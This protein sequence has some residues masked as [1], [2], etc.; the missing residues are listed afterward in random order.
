MNPETTVD[1]AYGKGRLRLELDR[2]L[3][4]WRVIRPKFEPPLPN[5]HAVFDEVCRAPIGSR[6]L[7]GVVDAKDRVV[8]VTSDGT[9]PVPN[10]LL[11]PWLLEELPV[12]LDQVTVLIGTGTHRGNT[13]DELRSMFGADLSRQVRFVNHD[14]S[15]PA[16]NVE[17]GRTETGVPITL[18]AEYVHADKRIV[19]GF[20]EPHFFAGFSGGPKGVIPGIAGLDTIFHIHG[21][22][23]IAHPQSTWGILTENPLQ[24][25]I[26]DMV[27]LCPPDFLVNVSLN[28][29]KNITG[30]FA[31]HY[32]EAHR[33]GCAHVRETAMIPVPHK[34]P[35]VV[36]SNSG[37]P[38]DQNLYQTVKGMSAAARITED[39]SAIF[40]ASECS[41]GIPAHGNFGAV[42]QRHETVASVDSWLQQLA[43]P[44]QDQW[45]IQTLVQILK[46][47]KVYLHSQLAPECVRACKLAPISSLELGLR[48][49][50]ET[51][52]RGAP[53]AV[54]PEGPVTI[55][56]CQES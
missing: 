30:V 32:I 22:D 5:P 17:I 7:R 9:R 1:I 15:D 35:V 52:G 19:L 12:P 53:V 49:H 31:G 39:D 25:A 36:T 18:N 23:L 16:Q 38:L 33:A 11:L 34:F 40:A 26:A 20:I 51:I 37:Y 27:A 54:L 56:Y 21:Y 50:I 45:Q 28:S 46:R 42:L 14:A 55:P 6:P 48:E 41:D 10:N 3:A 44:V 29:E 2:K 13:D 4:E 24:R 8:I 43:S 47:S